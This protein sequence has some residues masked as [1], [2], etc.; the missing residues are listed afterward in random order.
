M[1]IL[2]G[3]A[4]ESHTLFRDAFRMLGISRALRSRD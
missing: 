1:K 2:A 3:S 4:L